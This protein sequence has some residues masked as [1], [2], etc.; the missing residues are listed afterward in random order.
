MFAKITGL[1]LSAF[2]IASIVLSI[3]SVFLL[4]FEIVEKSWG[5]F[6]LSTIGFISGVIVFGIGCALYAVSEN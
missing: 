6:G 1:F 3:A 5:N 2:G 4:M